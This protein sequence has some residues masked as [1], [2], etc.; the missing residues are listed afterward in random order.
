M[1]SFRLLS[2]ATYLFIVLQSVTLTAVAQVSNFFVSNMPNISKLP[3]N[4]VTAIQQDAEGYMWYG[5]SD[6]LCRDDGYREYGPRRSRR[7]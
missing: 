4:E 7:R 3:V 2:L 6:G 5:T 1:K